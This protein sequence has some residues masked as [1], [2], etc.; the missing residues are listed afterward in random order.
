MI[1]SYEVFRSSL[2]LCIFITGISY[3]V[4]VLRGSRTASDDTILITKSE[5]EVIKQVFRRQMTEVSTPADERFIRIVV[6]VCV[7][8]WNGAAA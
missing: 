6:R 2:V 3:W 8:L 4:L 7:P 1:T 5:Y